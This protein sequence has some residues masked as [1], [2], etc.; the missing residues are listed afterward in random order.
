MVI[1]LIPDCPLDKVAG[2]GNAAGTGAR[3]ALLN[4][5]YRREIEELV[6][7]IEKIETALEPRF[8]EHFVNA[9]A[10]PNKTEP[11]PN[12]AAAVELAEAAA[13]R[14]DRSAAKADGV[15]AAPR[16]TPSSSLSGQRIASKRPCGKVNA[17]QFTCAR[18]APVRSSGTTGGGH[19]MSEV[20]V[21]GI[22]TRARACRGTSDTRRPRHFRAEVLIGADAYAA[23][24]AEWQRLAELQTGAILFQIPT[25]SPPGRAT[26]HAIR[27]ISSRSSC[28]RNGR[29][30]LIWPLL[31]ERRALVRVA[32]GAGAPIGQY[33][34]ILLDP[35]CDAA[36]ALRGGS[37]TRLTALSAALTSCFWS[38]SAPT[39]RFAHALS[40]IAPLCLRRRRA[41]CRSL[42]TASRHFMTSLKPRRARQ[43]RKRMRR[44]E[45]GRRG[46]VRG[47]A[48]VREQPRRGWS[49]R[50]R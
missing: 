48:R 47:R 43:Q 16:A 30:V 40:D 37:S 23:L 1:G 9:M 22:R 3:M 25:C 14:A 28:D 42:A 19:S 27:T 12:L 46:R 11:F 15:A 35:D 21:A 45:A 44:F 31:I 10:F 39:A 49:R 24:R 18:S 7:K 2:V 32:R 29:V 33:D 41:L 8:Q 26:S 20:A 13:K 50:W 6:R 36:D 17:R 4:K 38:G 34:E 5:G